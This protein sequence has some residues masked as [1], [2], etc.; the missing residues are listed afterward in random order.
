M[1]KLLLNAAATFGVAFGG[2]YQETGNARSALLAAI[3][4]T[5]ANVIGVLQEKPRK[6]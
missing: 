1:K 6:E 5:V 4:A 2:V 3:L